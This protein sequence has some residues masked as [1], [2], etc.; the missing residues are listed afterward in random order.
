MQYGEG[1]GRGVRVCERDVEA[2]ITSG[3]SRKSS[4]LAHSSE[5][6]E[7]SGALSSVSL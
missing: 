5:Q 6:L 1:Y 7:K 2:Q 3:C 4:D